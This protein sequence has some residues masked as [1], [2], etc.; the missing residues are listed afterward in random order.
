MEF[1]GIGG[2]DTGYDDS[3][4]T[5][6]DEA[7]YDSSGS[8]LSGDFGS[9]DDD[10]S[11]SGDDLSSDDTYGDPTSSTEVTTV[12]QDDLDGDGVVDQVIETT[13]VD[14]DG[15]GVSDM[16]VTYVD[17][18]ADGS[19]E[20]NTITSDYD[21]DADG[22]VDSTFTVDSYDLDSD[23]DY[24][25]VDTTSTDTYAE[26]VDSDGDGTTDT[27]ATTSDVSESS[28]TYTPLEDA[29]EGGTVSTTIAGQDVTLDASS[30][31][32]DNDGTTEQQA[33]LD[34]GED[35]SLILTDLDG[36]GGADQS[37]LT[38]G[39]ADQFVAEIDPETGEWTEP[40]PVDWSE[41]NTD[42]IEEDGAEDPTATGETSGDENTSVDG[43][44]TVTADTP[45]GQADVELTDDTNDDGVADTGTATVDGQTLEVSDFIDAGDGIYTAEVT[46][47]AGEVVAE[48]S[49]DGEWTDASGNPVSNPVS[50]PVSSQGT[51]TTSSS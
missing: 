36:D 43:G 29:A 14:T 2:E 3:T 23:G 11:S 24:D 50:S 51:S 18:D 8:D 9:S 25:Q 41:I 16:T 44:V 28:T 34:L 26:D 45:Y 27:V 31:D 6:L 37:L 30:V 49:A 12:S 40:G 48:Q 22:A 15:D 4:S 21:L 46:D 35:G 17:S 38:D 10:L 13:D 47:S 19:Y 7:S 39:N 33:E 32:S 20:Q 42:T 1:E 5:G